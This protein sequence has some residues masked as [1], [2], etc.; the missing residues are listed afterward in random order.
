MIGVA[1]ET[2][3]TVT[4]GELKGEQ[5]LTTKENKGRQQRSRKADHQNP[6]PPRQHHLQLEALPPWTSKYNK[7]S[8]FTLAIKLKK[9]AENEQQKVKVTSFVVISPSHIA[10]PGSLEDILLRVQ[11][12]MN[13]WRRGC[14][15]R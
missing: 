12:R 2:R 5:G 13:S 6:D 11:V 1:P 4:A 14:V 9:R 3:K 10:L 7:K 15:S 8:N